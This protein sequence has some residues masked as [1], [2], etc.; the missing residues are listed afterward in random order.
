MSIKFI[1]SI[2]SLLI[3]LSSSSLAIA[4]DFTL[5]YSPGL[6]TTQ[7]GQ[8]F[9]RFGNKFTLGY[10]RTGSSS[11]LPI[12]GL[13]NGFSFQ[14]LGLS[15]LVTSLGEE[16]YASISLPVAIGL[17]MFLNYK[18]KEKLSPS[19]GFLG[20]FE[21]IYPLAFTQ[22]PVHG[23]ISAG[24]FFRLPVSEKLNLNFSA[25]YGVMIGQ[26][27]LKNFITS[28]LWIGFKLFD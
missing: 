16:S 26:S 21:A 27:Q 5:G 1:K 28:D 9:Q 24:G 10:S 4:Q 3:V 11:L 20:S 15:Y 17:G 8:S 22:D 7:I 23:N 12:D 18:E 19:I 13:E 6:Y 14:N 2:V 25:R